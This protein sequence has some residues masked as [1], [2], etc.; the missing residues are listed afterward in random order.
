MKAINF[1]KTNNYKSPRRN[2]CVVEYEDASGKFVTKEFVSNKNVHS[3]DVM[4]DYMNQ[5]NIT[6]DKIKRIFTEREPCV[7]TISNPDHDCAHHILNFTSDAEV[8]YAYDYGV[9]EEEGA[10]ARANLA[11]FLEGISNG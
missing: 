3:E 6:G 5:H 2:V 9:T 11:K 4:I 8:T 1:R 7:Q 10:V